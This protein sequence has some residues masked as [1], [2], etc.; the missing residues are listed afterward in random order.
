MAFYL[1]T[2][3]RKYPGF[4]DLTPIDFF[5]KNNVSPQF[6][7]PKYLTRKWEVYS[8]IICVCACLHH[9]LPVILESADRFSQNVVRI[10]H[11]SIP[12]FIHHNLIPIQMQRPYEIMR[13]Q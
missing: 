13:W 12:H 6:F 4:W 8:I 7:W 11:Y 1:S 2:S 3:F 9:P 5:T 10:W